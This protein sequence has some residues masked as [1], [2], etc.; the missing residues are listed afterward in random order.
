MRPQTALL[1]LVANT[2]A[3]KVLDREMRAREFDV[4]GRLATAVPIRR[5]FP[6]SDPNRVRDL[7]RVIETDLI[8]LR[9]STQA[10]S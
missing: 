9:D 2:Y 6:H 4:L 7:C 10:R 5:V 1:D 3:N 8:A